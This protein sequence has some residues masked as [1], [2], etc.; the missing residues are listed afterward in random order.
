MTPA[1]LAALH[2]AA[3]DHDRPWSASEFAT[4]QETPYTHLFHTPQ[5]FAL[6]R[7]IAG[8]SELLTLAV[9]PGHQRKGIAAGLMQ[10]WLSQIATSA[11]TAFLEV[12]A[13]NHAAQALYR[14][15]GFEM[16]AT[17]AAYYHRKDAPSADA[18]IYRRRLT[19]R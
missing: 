5:G 15:F 1:A 16:V 12:A 2:A 19:H 8:E 10:Q 7:T 11:E 3:F 13:D 4:L 14:K 18:L 9:H 17:R 6:T